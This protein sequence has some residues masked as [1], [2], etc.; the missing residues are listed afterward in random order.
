M[1]LADG[2]ALTTVVISVILILV[3]LGS[4]KGTIH[5]KIDIL[6]QAKEQTDDEI[7]RLHGKYDAV[8]TLLTSIQ[9][10]IARNTGTLETTLKNLE[11]LVITNAKNIE[12]LRKR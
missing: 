6:F 12:D 11:G 1:T 9:V 10:S 2:L 7:T 5:Q 3:A 8:I 4:W